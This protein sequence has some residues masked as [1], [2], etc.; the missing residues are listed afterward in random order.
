M[1]TR[2]ETHGTGISYEHA[3]QNSRFATAWN[4]NSANELV[5]IHNSTVE[6][7][8]KLLRDYGHHKVDCWISMGLDSLCNCGFFTHT[9]HDGAWISPIGTEQEHKRARELA[10]Q[11]VG[12]VPGHPSWCALSKPHQGECQP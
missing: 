1:S 3:P 10:R 12:K 6:N 4:E 5:K 9:E 11:F 8:I 2:W 7:Y